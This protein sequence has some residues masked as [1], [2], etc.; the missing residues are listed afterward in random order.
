MLSIKHSSLKYIPGLRWVLLETDS[1]EG[2]ELSRLP[3]VRGAVG[4]TPFL[5]EGLCGRFGSRGRGEHVFHRHLGQGRSGSFRRRSRQ[6]AQAR[7]RPRLHRPGAL[8]GEGRIHSEEARPAC[9]SL[10]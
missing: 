7:Q 6:V 2:R 5:G 8:A 4:S 9:R 1:N 10:L 3:S